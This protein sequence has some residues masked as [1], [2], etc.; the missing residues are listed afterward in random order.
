MNVVVRRHDGSSSEQALEGAEAREQALAVVEPVDADDERAPDETGAQA[1]DRAAGDGLARHFGDPVGIDADRVDAGAEA[2]AEGVDRAVIVDTAADLVDDVVAK[3]AHIGRGLEA[4]QIIGRE[5]AHQRRVVGQGQQ[6]LPGRKRRVQEKADRL[7]HAE[8]AQR[9]AERD[10]LIVVHPDRVAVA[11][12]R[13]Q[14][15]REDMVDLEIAVIFAPLIFDEP[16]AVVEQR[17]QH[18]VAVAVVVVVEVL[19]VEVDRRIGDRAGRVEAK[20]AGLARHG[21]AAPAEPYA[22]RS[23]AARP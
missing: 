23:R 17:P 8:L 12:Q 3:R 4:D 1:L 21:L 9:G 14:P 7:A 11:Q 6:H 16:H 22:A 19:L 2:V 15:A 13:A 10:Q 18:A 20:R 5:R